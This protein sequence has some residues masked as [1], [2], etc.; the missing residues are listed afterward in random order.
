MLERCVHYDGLDAQAV[1]QLRELATRTG[2]RA[3]RAVNNR[4]A[5]ALSM[6]RG[7]TP[8]NPTRLTFGVYFY[9]E[10]Q[11]AVPSAPATPR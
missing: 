2:M 9:E 5:E 6:A 11:A 3:L 10:P 7:A 1:T 8:A 4:A